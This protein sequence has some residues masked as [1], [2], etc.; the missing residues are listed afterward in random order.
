MNFLEKS[1]QNLEKYKKALKESYV[2]DGITTISEKELLKKI[3]SALD[4]GYI[5]LAKNI[6]NQYYDDEDFDEYLDSKINSS[7]SK[8]KDDEKPENLSKSKDNSDK[9]SDKDNKNDVSYTSSG[10]IVSSEKLEEI[11]DKMSEDDSICFKKEEDKNRFQQTLGKDDERLKTQVD[12]STLF[13][14]K[15]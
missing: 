6:F 15:K 8:N 14:V 2:S 13:I 11:L 1:K 7:K 9:K 3:D 12:D 10:A 5:E 4:K